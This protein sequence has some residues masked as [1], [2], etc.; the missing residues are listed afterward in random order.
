MLAQPKGPRFR[1][2]RL[3][4]ELTLQRSEHRATSTPNAPLGTAWEEHHPAI[5][6]HRW[7]K[8][9]GRLPGRLLGPATERKAWV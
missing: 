8:S 3:N 9:L 6:P 2:A 1:R 7:G 5:S 4:P